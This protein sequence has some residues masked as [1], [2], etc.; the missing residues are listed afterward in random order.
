M[1]LGHPT[2]WAPEDRSPRD[3]G[4]R[5]F[6][7][8]KI[9]KLIGD[10]KYFMSDKKSE[11]TSSS[12]EINV[13]ENSRGLARILNHEGVIQVLFAL[14]DKPKLFKELSKELNLPSTTF[15]MALKDLREHVRIIRKTQTV[16]GNRDTHQYVLEPIGRE[17]I[18][19]IKD[20]ERFMVLSVPEQKVLEIEKTK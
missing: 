5:K 8:A 13:F 16:D 14:Q 6:R 17:L 4:A 19:F 7:G 18:R 9:F 2:S 3:S 15:E 12:I 11:N 10:K 1:I 20:Y